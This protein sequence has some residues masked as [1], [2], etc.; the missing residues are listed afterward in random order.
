VL[1]RHDLRAKLCA[2]ARSNLSAPLR[3]HAPL[4]VRLASA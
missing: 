3:I 4:Q 1:Q 2:A